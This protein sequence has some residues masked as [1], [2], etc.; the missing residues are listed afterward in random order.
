MMKLMII[1]KN[2]SYKLLEERNRQKVLLQQSDNLE[3]IEKFLS[4]K[5]GW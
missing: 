4:V 1:C 2:G 5:Y 3:S